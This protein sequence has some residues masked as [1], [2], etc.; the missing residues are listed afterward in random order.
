SEGLGGYDGIE[1]PDAGAIAKKVAKRHQTASAE[2]P[3]LTTAAELGKGQAAAASRPIAETFSVDSESF[4]VGMPVAHPKYGLGK[5]AALSGPAQRR[6]ATVNF[7]TAGVR[8]FRL[9]ESPLRPVG[10]KS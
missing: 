3:A 1:E 10:R 2:A 9:H 6:T 5:I 8:K 7:V 4:H